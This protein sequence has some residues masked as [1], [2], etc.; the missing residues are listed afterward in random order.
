MPDEIRIGFMG[1]TWP[2]KSHAEGFAPI[3]GVTF[4]A[5]SEPLKERRDQF[6]AK[7][8]QMETYEDYHEMLKHAGLDAVVIGLPTGMHFDASCAALRA[9]C[10]VLCENRPPPTPAR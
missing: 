9:G 2:C 7:F 1:A 5:I 10:H 8:G 4:K 6:A 3:K